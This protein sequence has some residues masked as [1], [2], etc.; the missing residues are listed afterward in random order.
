MIAKNFHMDTT[1]RLKVMGVDAYKVGEKLRS[2][3]FVDDV[4][5]DYEYSTDM[6]GHYKKE[7]TFRTVLTKNG[8]RVF[9][10]DPGE[11][12]FRLEGDRTEIKNILMRL[13]IPVSSFDKVVV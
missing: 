1:V 9:I 4:G 13:K 5:F 11:L 3:G 8:V 12:C 7:K 6:H 10:A 2:L